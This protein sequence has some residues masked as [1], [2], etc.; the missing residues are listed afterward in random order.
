MAED[1]GE[2]LASRRPSKGKLLIEG[3]FKQ[4]YKPHSDFSCP[5]QKKILKSFSPVR[6]FP[7]LEARRRLPHLCN[8]C[9]VY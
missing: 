3:M 6:S 8:S 4:S 9:K 7:R 2:V 1:E 5:S